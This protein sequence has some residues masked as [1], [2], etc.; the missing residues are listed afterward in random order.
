MS[1]ATPEFLS[2]KSASRYGT[3]IFYPRLYLPYLFI[4]LRTFF[5]KLET[6]CNQGRDVTSAAAFL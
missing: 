4:V 2:L 3:F 5:L 6:S 1:S